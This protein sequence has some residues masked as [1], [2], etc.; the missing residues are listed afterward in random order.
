MAV[1]IS[2]NEVLAGTSWRSWHQS[3]M[4]C[5]PLVNSCFLSLERFRKMQGGSG[6]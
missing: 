5:I 3:E 6:G 1:T 4:R 2:S